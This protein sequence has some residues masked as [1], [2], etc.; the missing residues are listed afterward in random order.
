M[1]YFASVIRDKPIRPGDHFPAMGCYADGHDLRSLVGIA[2]PYT[3]VG[4]LKLVG[5]PWADY[6]PPEVVWRL[7]IDRA[8]VDQEIRYLDDKLALDGRYVLRSGRFVE[9]VEDAE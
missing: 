7:V 5:E 8:W 6:P 4:V 2:Y 3:H 1:D 9:L